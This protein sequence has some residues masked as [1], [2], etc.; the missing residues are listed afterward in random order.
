MVANNVSVIDRNT[1]TATALKAANNPSA[2][3]AKF[4]AEFPL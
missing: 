4:R 1:N 2:A 3:A